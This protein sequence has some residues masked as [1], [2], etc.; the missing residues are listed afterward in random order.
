MHRYTLLAKVVGGLNVTDEYI[1][2]KAAI[3]KQLWNMALKR[4][5]YG[6]FGFILTNGTRPWEVIG[7]QTSWMVRKIMQAGHWIFEAGISMTEIMEA[8]YFTIKGM[9]RK[10]RG[11]SSKCRG[12]D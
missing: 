7:K 12:E 11:D 9:Y 8:E 1:W 10:L 5:S 4:T 3:H 6:L 2:N